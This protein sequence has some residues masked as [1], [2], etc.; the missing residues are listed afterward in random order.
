[1]STRLGFAAKAGSSLETVGVTL[2]AGAA[3]ALAFQLVTQQ[4]KPKRAATP[5]GL[6]IAALQA[7]VLK[8]SGRSGIEVNNLGG[9]I[10][11]VV[12]E[13]TDV[14]EADRL[15]ASVTGAPGVEVVLDRLW[16]RTPR[17]VS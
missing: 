12:G 14:G 8:L 5:Q 1:M 17:L 7:R 6:D 10:I 2:L 16:V 3:A 13:S 4:L 9:G 15:I 11:E